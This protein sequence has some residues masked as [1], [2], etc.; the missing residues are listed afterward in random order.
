MSDFIDA[1]VMAGQHPDTF[2]APSTNDLAAIKPGDWIKV[3]R[4]S[5]RFWLMVRTINGQTITGEVRN[6][7]ISNPDLTMGTMIECETR[8]VYAIDDP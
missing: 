1:Q 2:H 4:N 8:H 5:E 6:M 7:L 3:C